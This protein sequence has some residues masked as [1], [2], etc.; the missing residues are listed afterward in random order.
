LSDAGYIITRRPG[1]KSVL[2]S[3]LAASSTDPQTGE[4]NVSR[5]TIGVRNVVIEPTSYK[6]RVA[7]RETQEEIGGV[8]L[9]FYTRDVPFRRLNPTD[10]VIEGSRRLQVVTSTVEDTVLRVT[11]NEQVGQA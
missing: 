1:S 6:R 11:A 8:T 9:L 3:R 2:V 10:C 5:S 7:A 4:R